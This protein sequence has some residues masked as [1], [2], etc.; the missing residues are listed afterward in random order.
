MLAENAVERVD[1]IIGLCLV[2]NRASGR[3]EHRKGN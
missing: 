1:E 2:G 3:A